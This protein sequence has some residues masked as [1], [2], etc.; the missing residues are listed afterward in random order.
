MVMVFLI[1]YIHDIQWSKQKITNFL[2]IKWQKHWMD[3]DVSHF[4][5]MKKS[6]IIP[7]WLQILNSWATEQLQI[8]STKNYSH[9]WGAHNACFVAHIQGAITKLQSKRRKIKV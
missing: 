4:N 8:I 5:V 2:Q 9:R 1:T 7:F 6:S 3:G